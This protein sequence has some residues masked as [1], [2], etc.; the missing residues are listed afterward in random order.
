MAVEW[1][2][3]GV[4]T[5]LAVHI[6]FQTRVKCRLPHFLILG[7]IGAVLGG[8]MAIRLCQHGRLTSP[9]TYPPVAPVTGAALLVLWYGVPK[10]RGTDPHAHA[11]ECD[12]GKWTL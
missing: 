1:I 10:W 5:G 9:C 2:L 3:L 4:L 11:K 7:V 8:Y 6:L 12:R